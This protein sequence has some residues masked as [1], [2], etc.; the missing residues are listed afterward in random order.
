MLLPMSILTFRYTT[1]KSVLSLHVLN[2]T[3]KECTRVR[4]IAGAREQED[5]SY[6]FALNPLLVEVLAQQ[7]PAL[8]IAPEVQD[9][10]NDYK[11]WLHARILLRSAADVPPRTAMEARLHPYQRV[12]VAWLEQGKRVILADKMGLGKTPMSLLACKAVGARRI[13]IV[14]YAIV[15]QQWQ[16]EVATWLGAEA[17][18]AEGSSDE[19]AALI[20][21]KPD[22]LIINYEMLSSC[23]AATNA[24]LEKPPYLAL[25]KQ[26]WDVVIF[27][28]AHRLQNHKHSE[29]RMA[30]AGATLSRQCTY[31]FEL[32]GTPFWNRPDSIWHL[33]HMLDARR[34]SSYWDF[35]FRYCVVDETQWGLK[36]TGA[37]EETKEEFQRILGEFVLQRTKEQVVQQLPPKLHHDIHY[38]L[39]KEQKDTYAIIKKTLVLPREDAPDIFLANVAASLAP[40][41]RLCNAPA[42]LGYTDMP[43]AKDALVLSLVDQILG[44]NAKLAIFCW[45][46]DYAQYL[47]TI[48]RRKHYRVS[49]ATDGTASKRIEVVEQFK[50]N[51]DHILIGTMGGLGVGIS[52][53]NIVS[54]IIFTEMDWTPLVNEQAED[55]FHRFTTRAPVTI[56]RLIANQTIE[57][58]V[59]NVYREKQDITDELMALREVLKKL[60]KEA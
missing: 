7:L 26:R 49:K 32:T 60:K 21:Q 57:E 24:P 11:S 31:L 41:R 27:D 46:Q 38:S 30:K 18:V 6:T 43:S 34:F 22:I 19:R 51:D 56:Y 4:T 47:T 58:H 17:H 16:H 53:D 59:Y 25:L 8:H 35:V 13:L 48:L 50:Q 44:E 20:A 42:L 39:S 9:W 45:H 15:K 10:Y 14:T 37:K 52:L 40:L 36:I 28:E 23:Y 1:K 12:G 3:D 5:A 54:H 55:R 2:L 33:L 29:S